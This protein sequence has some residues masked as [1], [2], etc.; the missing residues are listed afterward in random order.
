MSI[1]IAAPPSPF[2][3]LAAFEDSDLDAL[4]FFGR[5]RESEVIAAN[6]IA[7]RVTVLY[8]PSGVGKSSVL[9]AG[10]AHRLRRE[11]GAAVIVYATW[12]GD[13]VAALVE[14]AGGS[15]ESLVDAL[16]DAADRAGGDLYVILDQFE[17]CFLYQERGGA[18]A[19][20]LAELLQRGLRVNVLIGI[21]EDALARLDALK[22]SIPN[23]LSNRL[24]LERLDR[25]AG[26]AAILGPIQRYN[27]LVPHDEAVAVEP[28]LEQAI[29]DQVTAGKVDL[30]ST[31]RGVALTVHDEKRIEAPY[32]QLVLARLWDV[33]RERGSRVMR[34]ATLTELGGA[35]RIVQD[36]LERAMAELSP[37]EKVAAAA[38]YHFLVT[39]SGT[40]IAHGLSDL[41]GYA[42]VE[43]REA[44]DVLR[45]LTAERIVRASSENGPSTTRYE[46]F[47]DVLA[48]AV[49]AWRTRYEGERAL[50]E[51]RVEH[52]RRQ[53]R[54]LRIFAVA[55]LGFAVMAAIA[56]Y[57]LAQRNEA[58]QQAAL[59]HTQ[60]LK[61][62]Q[63][64]VV[65]QQA[66]ADQTKS[67]NKA[68]ASAKSEKQAAQVAQVNEQKAK[69][70]AASERLAREGESR[71]ARRARAAERRANNSLANSRAQ[72]R[73]AE[74]QTRLHRLAAAK[75][76][77]AESRATHERNIV[78]ARELEADARVLLAEDPERSVRRSLRAVRAYRRARIPRPVGVEDTL[79]E[80]LVLLRLRAVLPTGGAVH[81][82]RFGP[83]G[84]SLVFVGGAGGARLYDLEHR[85]ARRRLLPSFRVADAA[86]SPD[87]TLVVAAG[88]GTDRSAHVWD[89]RTGAELFTLAHGGPVLSVDFSP[90]GG[91][92]ATGSADGTARIWS[93]AGGL[94]LASFVHDR[95]ARGDD[96]QSVSFSPDGKRLVTVGGNRFARVFDVTRQSEVFPG[97]LNN[98]QLVNSARFSHGGKLIATAGAGEQVRVWDASTGLPIAVLN[99]SGRV[100]DLA[101][102]PDDTLLA[103]A[104]TNDTI[105]RVWN[106]AQQSATAI[107]TMHRSGVESV[108]FTPDGRSV[109][110]TGRDSKAYLSGPIGGFTH[111][112]LAGHT[113]P[114]EGATVSPDGG[115]VA[116]WSK[117]GRARLW[118]ARVGA[119]GGFPP[120]DA[121]VLGTHG[122]P[123][124][125][126]PGPV[127]AFSPDG[128][129]ILSAG[130]DAT[131]HL[132]GPGNQV[133][134]LQHDGPVNSASFSAKT[135]TLIT[136]SDD[137]TARVWRV[138]DGHL[139]AVLRHGSAVEV[140]RLTPD[141]RHAITAGRD[142]QLRVWSVATER[143]QWSYSHKGPINDAEISP[144]GRLVVTA[145]SDGTAGI[146]G[147]AR[148][149]ATVLRGHSEE[150]VAAVF[151]PDSKRVATA[152]ADFTARIWDVRTGSS[153]ELAGHTGVLNALAFN[154]GG[155]L[156][157][158]A[159]GDNDVRVWNGVSG[160]E[161][162]VLRIHSGAVTDVAFSADGR[163][164]ASAGPLAAGIWETRKHGTWPA[165]PQYLVRG[166]APPRLDHV[167]FSP[168]GWQLLTGWRN[169]A[170][171]LYNCRLCG[172]TLQLSAIARGQL[173][174]IV[175]TKP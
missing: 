37:Q 101:F 144:D 19:S 40:K 56:I 124:G 98:I 8:G 173:G 4:L 14:A 28:Q 135:L 92:I 61:A 31:G 137:G 80:G 159:G 88:S 152:S 67:A 110:T 160:K 96:V 15:G 147:V 48:G 44:G 9:R 12:T 39:P 35:E 89:T 5:G 93:A 52:Q 90:V 27:E 103:T 166:S 153:H 163:W 141:G 111:A 73:I 107:L 26:E 34:F 133:K 24:R 99:G 172:G 22:A 109:I 74:R 104:G 114:V 72:T 118:E 70:A 10:V 112:T 154:R 119:F 87:G 155:S 47:H 25:L 115:L 3:G 157:A 81:V 11:Q 83:Q 46:I 85:F 150:V 17:E 130:A 106:I 122:P 60:Q 146:W 132:R 68:K 64:V 134:I 66:K 1:A 41:A 167:A 18:F 117:D 16:A 21:R 23:L 29:L 123:V 86:F 174:E 51:E 145:G 162:A 2:K 164:L 151:S 139:L 156:L 20:Q 149:S 82:V 161:V 32:L 129:Y 136:G 143:P 131:A 105:A 120:A 55:L 102:S 36:H 108:T 30:G 65:A 33:E 125:L 69:D 58:Q 38:M 116:T 113:G 95:G 128:R 45:R 71:E 148:K 78:R 59:A 165:L 142:G 77:R 53:R 6:L 43:E 168:R 42:S 171:R 49:V 57:A 138:S 91:L 127:V 79:R 169:G 62:E 63:A 50:A 84:S 76:L 100:T 7:S 94:Q 140:A 97:G 13:P 175:R 158:T 75:A 54:L 121:Q 126:N 170:V